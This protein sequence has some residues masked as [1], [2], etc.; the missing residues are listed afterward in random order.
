MRGRRSM[1][2][3]GARRGKRRSFRRRSG[4]GPLRIG[5]RF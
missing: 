1:R 5:S 3:R 2:R 4:V